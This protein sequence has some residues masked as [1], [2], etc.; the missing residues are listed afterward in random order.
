PSAT[1]QSLYRAAQS[2]N[3]STVLG[4]L[5]QIKTVSDYS[6]VN[7]YYKDIPIISKTIVNDLLNYAFSG[8]ETAKEQI[9]HEFLR[10]G[11]KVNSTGVWSLQGIRLYKDLITIRPTVVI[12]SYNH[13]IT[14]PRNTILGDEIKIANGTTWFRTVDS[15]IL[16]VPTQDVKYAN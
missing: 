4:L 11:L 13:R 15:G 7:D 3:L 16:R 6:S 14:V 5:Q 8:N 2:K 12:D 10:I 1:A 9:R